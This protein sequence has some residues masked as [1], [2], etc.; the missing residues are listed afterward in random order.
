MSSKKQIT[1][2]GATGNI[3]NSVAKNLVNL[4]FEVKAIVRNQIKAER[5]FKNVPQIQIEK[6]DLT[7]ISS[8]KLALLGTENLYLNLSTQSTKINTSFAPDREGVENVLSALDKNSIK[9]IICI[10]GLGALDNV[11]NPEKFKFIP[12]VLRKQG[13]KLIKESG[14]PY[15][16]LHC[17]WFIDSFV[18]YERNHTYAVIGDTENPIY[19]TNCLD[20]ANHVANAIGNPD[21]F[22]KEFPIQ[23]KEG[24]KHP[25]AA[26]EFFSVYDKDVK[27]NKLPS[28]LI[29]FLSLFKK[30]FKLLK[31]MSDYFLKSTETFIA[32]EYGTYKILGEPSMSIME[33]AKMI[34]KEKSHDDLNV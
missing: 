15:T 17:S 29:G 1:I 2:I 10:S 13:H 20:F 27:V 21:A 26:R 9:Q 24:F 7:D 6:A 23:G 32:E 14:I 8:L 18:F 12:N 3:G 31:H 16:I 28:G 30:D 22:F 34:K 11:Q 5:L 4:G 33:Y 25:Q 19:F